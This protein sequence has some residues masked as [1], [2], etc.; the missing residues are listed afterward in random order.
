[1]INAKTSV[2]N[3]FCVNGCPRFYNAKPRILKYRGVGFKERPRVPA[4]TRTHT[5][6]PKHSANQRENRPHLFH[7]F[8]RFC[9][10]FAASFFELFA[11]LSQ[12]KVPAHLLF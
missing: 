12:I 9:V 2:G 4:R 6:A 7:V 5:P 3:F 8:P 10:D 1:M 11:S